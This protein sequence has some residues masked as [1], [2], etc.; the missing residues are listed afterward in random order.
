MRCNCCRQSDF[1]SLPLVDCSMA[2]DNRMMKQAAS[3]FLSCFLL[4]VVAIALARL[5]QLLAPRVGWPL[6]VLLAGGGLG[7]AAL[8]LW[9]QQLVR[10]W[11]LFLLV[12]IL[13]ALFLASAG[14]FFEWRDAVA[15]SEARRANA[16]QEQP[17]YA[18][19]LEEQI[20]TPTWNEFMTPAADEVRTWAIWLG[21]AAAK[22]AL[23][24]A[25]LLAGKRQGWLAQRDA[26]GETI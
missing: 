7:A 13:A 1:D 15:A 16:I 20:R 6:I 11:P 10:S 23:T 8:L 19:L 4:A 24:L 18:A 12:T 25:I 3:F 2:F 5:S 9:Q 21:D 26:M 14:H 17:Q 22:L